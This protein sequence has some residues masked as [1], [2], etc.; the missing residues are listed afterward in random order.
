ML[1]EPN[2]GER[3]LL[4]FAGGEETYILCREWNE[5]LPA[6]TLLATPLTLS[7]TLLR[8]SLILAHSRY[9]WNWLFREPYLRGGKCALK[10]VSW[11]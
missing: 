4:S 9:S 2:A 1:T 8:G 5:G 3:D 6:I 7:L 10:P 11:R